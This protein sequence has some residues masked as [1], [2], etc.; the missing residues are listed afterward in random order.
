MAL[1]S[2]LLTLV[3]TLALVRPAA[4]QPVGEPQRI[5]IVD[6]GTACVTAPTACAIFSLDSQTGSITLGI[7]G[8]WTG[9]LTFEG[10]NN[11]SIW[12]SVS[13]INQA[14]GSAVT[15][16]TANGLFAITNIG[17]IEVRARATAAITGGPIVTAAK[18]LGS[19]GAPV[20]AAG[21]GLTDLEL[22]ATPV[23]VSGTLTVD[24]TGLATSAKQDTAQTS[25]S[26]IKLDVDKIPSQGQALAAAS[27]PV[28]LTAAQMTTLTPIATVADGANA[29]LGATTDS[30][31]IET[32]G[33]S[34]TV[35][36]LL[37]QI[38]YT[39]QNPSSTPVTGTVAVSNG[40]TTDTDDGTVA[41]AQA[42]VALT[43]GLN[44]LWDGTNWKR[45]L[46]TAAAIGTAPPANAVFQG[47]IGSGA[48]GGF[49]VGAAVADTQ[50]TVN[51][52]TAT[53]TLLI[54]GVSGRHVRVSAY[55]LVT[56]LA[57]NVGIISGT[58]ATCGTGT[59]AIVGTTA[60][61]GYN[62]GANGGVARGTGQGTV[63][64]TVATGDSICLIT[65]AATQLSGV[66]A[67]AIY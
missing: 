44:Q 65:S 1:K 20:T 64:R 6:S 30:K 34:A 8:T 56:A 60:A 17:V 32:G 55:D 25:L 66:W 51:I 52:S 9:T 19:A 33:V 22:R 54:T 16:T 41:G 39:G 12:T 2:L 46:T 59:A 13:A 67:Y 23:P 42:S 31:S 62:F 15:T 26:A 47:G 61:T 43:L 36:A 24:T 49:L 21:G 48:T 40:S 4:A 37:K 14:T 29:A 7:T 10:T 57:N 28:V 38:S 18:G 27:T 35:V 50:A 58:G 45:A 53:T 5:T 63:L 11:G 3:A